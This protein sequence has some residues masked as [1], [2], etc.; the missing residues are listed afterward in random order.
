[1]NNVADIYQNLLPELDTDKAI[2]GA[3]FSS[4]VIFY[5]SWAQ[6]WSTGSRKTG[7]V[8]DFKILLM[9]S[10]QGLTHR[11]TRE[12]WYD[13]HNGDSLSESY[14]ALP[15]G[16]DI[17]H[18]GGHAY[19]YLKDIVPDLQILQTSYRGQ[20]LLE[21]EQGDIMVYE[22]HRE[23]KWL[24]Y[25][26]RSGDAADLWTRQWMDAHAAQY[27]RIFPSPVYGDG[28]KTTM[29]T[30]DGA[31]YNLDDRWIGL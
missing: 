18:E 27:F 8:C 1:M 30:P 25:R 15:R 12:Y 2:A 17:A 3:S 26:I 7:F 23:V 24:D 5:D 16:A 13:A 21:R 6:R 10:A 4:D 11:R 20:R 28:W 14:G 29:K 31:T 22:L 19:V 9:I